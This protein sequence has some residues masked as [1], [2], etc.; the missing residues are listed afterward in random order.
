ML[1]AAPSASGEPSIWYA[2]VE[3][4]HR[5]FAGKAM[6]HPVVVIGQYLERKRFLRPRHANFI[7]VRVQP[8]RAPPAASGTPPTLRPSER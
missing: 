3:Q 6:A 5:K 7:R 8:H 2:E 4:P 1:G